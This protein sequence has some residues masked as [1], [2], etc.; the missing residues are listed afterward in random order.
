IYAQLNDELRERVQR[1][2]QETG[3]F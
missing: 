3:A 1:L 2:S